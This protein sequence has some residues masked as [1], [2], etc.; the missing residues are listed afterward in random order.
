MTVCVLCDDICIGERYV[1]CMTICMFA[2]ATECKY[3]ELTVCTC[4]QNNTALSRLL[5]EV[6]FSNLKIYFRSRPPFLSLNLKCVLTHV[7]KIV[8]IISES[9]NF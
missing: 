4:C 1:Y 5:V 7:L 3:C 8:S 6:L 2:A 9:Q